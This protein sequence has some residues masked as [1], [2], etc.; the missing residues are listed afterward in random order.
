MAE[1]TADKRQVSTDALQTLGSIIGEAETRD[2]IHLAVEP[3]VAGELLVPGQHVGRKKDGTFGS[4]GATKALGI[5]DPFIRDNVVKGQRFWLIIYPRQITSLHHVWEH[6]DFPDPVKLRVEKVRERLTK[7]HE[8]WITEF[9]NNIETDEYGNRLSFERVME[10]AGEYLDN[11]SDA[12]MGA[13]LDYDFLEKN[14][15][16]FWE[17]YSVLT[18]RNVPEDKRESF[19]RCAC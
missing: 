5:V 19:F 11:G 7:T 1:A 17:H 2:A 14:I 12:C 16:T 9:A 6:P 15:A 8:N 13:D 18:G 10:A 4:S 3:V